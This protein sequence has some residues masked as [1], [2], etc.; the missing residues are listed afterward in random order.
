MSKLNWEWLRKIIEQKIYERFGFRE[1]GK[2]IRVLKYD[3]GNY[4]DE[5]KWYCY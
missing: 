4:R 1:A 3:D 5:Y 2:S